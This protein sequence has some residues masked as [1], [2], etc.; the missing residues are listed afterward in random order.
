M[1]RCAPESS[2]E[3]GGGARNR[4]ARRRALSKVSTHRRVAACAG[5]V[6]SAR[7]RHRGRAPVA[8]SRWRYDAARAEVEWVADRTDGPDA[9]M[10]R[11]TALEFLTRWAD[12][13]P[14]RDEVRV[15]DAGA[16]ATRPGESGPKR[17]AG[18]NV[19]SAPRA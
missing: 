17:S 16:C 2:L 6:V 15:R 14:K 9:G 4:L 13:V 12:H 11:M 5:P 19:D 10:H 18:T 3:E 1:S 8:E 7:R